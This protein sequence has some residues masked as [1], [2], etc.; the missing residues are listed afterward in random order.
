MMSKLQLGGARIFTAISQ[1]AGDPTGT[2]TMSSPVLIP[3][4]GGQRVGGPQEVNTTLEA[5]VKE[6]STQGTGKRGHFKYIH[7]NCPVSLVLF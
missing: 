4:G 1:D 5:L 2:K 6:L 7:S 3:P